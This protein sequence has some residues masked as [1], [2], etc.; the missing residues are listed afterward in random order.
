MWFGTLVAVSWWNDL[1]L[2]EAVATFIAF[3]AMSRSAKLAEF[4]STCWVT[5]LE[6]KFW[7]VAKDNLSSTH[8][9]CCS[10][11]SHAQAGSLYDGISYGKGPAF[12]KQ[13]FNLLGEETFSHGIKLYFSKHA[14]SHAKLSDFIACLV[15]AFNSKGGDPQ[16]G[17]NFDLTLWCNTWF[18]TSGIN[19]L[20]PL[21]ETSESGQLLSLKIVQSPAARGSSTL[22]L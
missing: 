12:V 18:N 6:Y 9:I 19:T 7:G 17:P 21:V 13:L 16:L 20:E 15:A 2:N 1:G 5:F 8:P 4:H 22:R 11:V 3:L 10:H 14:W